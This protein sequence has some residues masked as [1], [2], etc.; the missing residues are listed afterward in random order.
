[1]VRNWVEG[2]SRT[3]D[4]GERI[5]W[6][7]KKGRRIRKGDTGYPRDNGSFVW[8]DTEVREI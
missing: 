2:R 5:K 4:E 7:V 1:M 6:E 8:E 3:R